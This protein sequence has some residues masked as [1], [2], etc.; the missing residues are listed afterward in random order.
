MNSK[1]KIKHHNFKSA[2]TREGKGGVIMGELARTP[3]RDGGKKGDKLGGKIEREKGLACLSVYA[4]PFA[5]PSPKKEV[6]FAVVSD[7]QYRNECRN[8]LTDC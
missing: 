7:Y 6:G 2:E 5:K 3:M 4:S 8:G 1:L